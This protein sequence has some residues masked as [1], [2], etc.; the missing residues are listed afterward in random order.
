MEDGDHGESMKRPRTLREL[1][2]DLFA[3]F[4]ELDSAGSA[5]A[6]EALSAR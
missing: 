1:E 3:A 5:I 2:R 6:M 4:V